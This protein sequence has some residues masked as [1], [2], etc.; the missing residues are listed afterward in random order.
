MSVSL[1]P[2]LAICGL[3]CAVI[4]IILLLMTSR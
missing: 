3:G 2:V 4:A 1:G